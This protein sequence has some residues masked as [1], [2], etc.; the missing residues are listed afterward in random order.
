MTLPIHTTQTAAPQS[1]PIF[2]AITQARGFVPNVYAV[3]GGLPDA[4]TGFAGLTGAFGNSSLTPAEREVIQ[5]AVSV[6]NRCRYCVAGH[7]AFAA[8]AE[9][10]DS[11]V[12][13]MRAGCDPD[14][15]RLGALARFARK[16]TTDRGRG[17]SEEYAGFL[18]AG[19]H[20][21]Q[22][23]EVIIG[24]ANKTLSNM[25]ANLLDLPLDAEFAPYA[26]VPKAEAV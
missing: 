10:S 2:N 15:D 19:Y 7:T 23:L 21:D 17:C 18:A 14:D 24:V 1:R 8:D 3:Y 9:L 5:L 26:W 16:L 12:Q 20:P 22:A 4:M 13:A 25:T 6:A 11:H